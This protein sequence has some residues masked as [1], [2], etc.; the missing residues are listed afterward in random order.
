MAHFVR[1]FDCGKE[2]HIIWLKD[3]GCQMKK[4]ISGDRVDIIKTI[5]GNP[6]PGSPTI[7][8]PTEFAYVHFQLCMKYTDAVLN[9]TAFVPPVLTK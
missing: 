1:N 5:N 4:S 2:E 6:L 9:G 8:N 7:D 3:L